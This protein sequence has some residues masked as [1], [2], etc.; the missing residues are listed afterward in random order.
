MNKGKGQR[1]KQ[2]ANLDGNSAQGMVYVYKVFLF[3][4]TFGGKYT[5]MRERGGRDSCVDNERD[6][7][8]GRHCRR[9]IHSQVLDMVLLSHG[10]NSFLVTTHA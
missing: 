10:Y 4:K 1:C 2:K 5:G 7:M 3:P 6:V 9:Q 8:V